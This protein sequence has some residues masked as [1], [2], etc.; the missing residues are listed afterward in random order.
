MNEIETR[1][2]PNL[3]TAAGLDV[4]DYLIKQASGGPAQKISA[5]MLLGAFSS[6]D[7]VV[8]TSAELVTDEEAQAVAVDRLV[9]VYADPDK[10]KSGY[11]VRVANNGNA[12]DFELTDLHYAAAAAQVQELLDTVN[13][14]REEVIIAQSEAVNAAMSIDSEAE[15]ASEFAVVDEYGF[16]VLNVAPSQVGFSENIADMPFDWELVIVT[17]QSLATGQG[18]TPI[19]SDTSLPSLKMLSGGIKTY[20]PANTSQQFYDDQ[21]IVDAVETVVAANGETPA[22]A[23]GEAI[24]EALAYRHGISLGDKEIILATHGQAG[25]P[26]TPYAADNPFYLSMVN[27]VSAIKAKADAVGKTFGIRAVCWVQGE[28]DVR[29]SEDSYQ[30][31]FEDFLSR[32][33]SD[34]KNITG[35]SQDIKILTYQTSSHSFYGN[36]SSPITRPH[37]ALAQ[38]S[39]AQS[40]DNIHMITPIYHMDTS[41]GVHLLAVDSKWLGGYFGNAFVRCVAED[42]EWPLPLPVA[43]TKRGKVARI[44]FSHPIIR[45]IMQTLP[46]DNDGFAIIDGAGNN[47]PIVRVSLGG[48][49]YIKIETDVLL[50]N[51]MKVRYGFGS[52]YSSQIFGGR[53]T[54]PRGNYRGIEDDRVFRDNHYRTIHSHLPIFEKGI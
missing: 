3:P 49:R 18:A 39:A 33:D 24:V 11:W 40:N 15:I 19:L 41:D 45:D 46:F 34:V 9:A 30:T 17:G 8:A 35:Q 5:K 32:F 1:D 43:V 26:I 36:A 54:G 37:S 13:G 42:G 10:R 53:R 44:E 28:S 22:R 2:I 4:D 48:D 23:T 27:M 25:I 47:I 29:T 52:E 38:L 50:P 20:N 6:A 14:V 31:Q 51:D 7:A 21:N 12:A 16:P